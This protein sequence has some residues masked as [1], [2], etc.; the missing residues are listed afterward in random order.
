MDTVLIFQHPRLKKS[1][2]IILFCWL[3]LGG[4]SVVADNNNVLPTESSENITHI[5]EVEH[6]S[7]EPVIE[8]EGTWTRQIINREPVNDYGNKGTVSL[9]N[10]TG[11]KLYFRAL[12]KGFEGALNLL[13]TRHYLQLNYIWHY[14]LF[15]TTGRTTVTVPRTGRLTNQ[16]L[17]YLETE[18][19]MRGFFD[20]R[21]WSYHPVWQGEWR[22]EIEVVKPEGITL[23][24]GDQIGH[25]EFKITVV[26]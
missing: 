7:P 21:S 8:I 4:N 12:I 22:V 20:W 11:G 5:D 3:S 18:L 6:S 10:L 9:T 25:C 26:P 1:C 13:E 19:K 14:T 17:S 15:T 2:L 23:K 16:E 24:C